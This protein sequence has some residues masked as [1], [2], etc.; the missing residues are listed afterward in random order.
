MARILVVEDVG[1]LAL[2]MADILTSSGFEVVGPAA[3]VAEALALIRT[4]G[5]DAA[6]LDINLRGETSEAIAH[7][8]KSRACPFISLT[9]YTLERLPAV[10]ADAPALSKPVRSRVLI[11]ELRRCLEG[12]KDG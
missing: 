7:E 9:G 8:L 4:E 3:S 11:A 10:F 2:T 5:C 6:L 1:L 12:K